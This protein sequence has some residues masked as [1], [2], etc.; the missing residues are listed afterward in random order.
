MER[1]SGLMD[2]QTKGGQV[3]ANTGSEKRQEALF[4]VGF[5]E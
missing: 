5:M 2:L 1:K 4:A 3:L